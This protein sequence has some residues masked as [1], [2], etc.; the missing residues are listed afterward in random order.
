MTTILR[1][2]KKNLKALQQMVAHGVEDF[3]L[4]YRIGHGAG[5]RDRAGHGC[6]CEDEVSLF[7]C[8]I[9]PRNKSQDLVL[10]FFHHAG[11]P[12]PHR[13]LRA[14]DIRG[15]G[16][17]RTAC[18]RKLAVL[19]GQITPHPSFPRS[20]RGSWSLPDTVNDPFLAGSHA[21]ARSGDIM[22]ESYL[23]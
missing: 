8:G 1:M 9:P 17:N 19:H 6:Y 3:L 5:K 21:P 4:G 18:L 7:L 11:D 14:R 16:C 20:P 2:Q 15:K 13:R 22:V 23:A 10:M 12:L